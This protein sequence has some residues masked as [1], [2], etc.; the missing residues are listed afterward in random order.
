MKQKIRR[1]E[2]L[3]WGGAAAVAGVTC[4]FVRHRS[5]PALT[6]VRLRAMGAPLELTVPRGAAA[7][8][9]PRVLGPLRE[10]EQ[11]MSAFRPD[12]ELSRLNAAAASA[13]V[14]LSGPLATVLAT[15]RRF[16]RLTE[17][18]FDPTVGPLLETWG[19][20]SLAARPAGPALREAL[21]RVG[22]DRVRCDGTRVCFAAE[23]VAVDLGGIA[24]G[25]GVDQA[26]GALAAG[27]GCLVNAGGDVRAAGPRPDGAPWVVG[28][29][30]PVGG[31]GVFATIQL[32][33]NRAVTTSG[34][35]QKFVDVGR[36]RVS[37]IFDP[38]TGDSP[39]EVISA[40]VVADTAMEADALAT[41]CVV[42]G[43]REAL[44]LLERVPRVEGLLVLR[45]GG[46]HQIEGTPG[47]AARILRSV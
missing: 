26:V 39:Q 25:Y 21:G 11:R 19:F 38:R 32:E 33:A 12:S 36:R 23:G 18:A 15:C 42:L 9:V 13:E 14:E 35:Y 47:L 44:A 45:R 1:R 41:A 40:T 22:L 30:D 27:P 34:T 3:W 20:R 31:S 43:G 37:H 24:V 2:L 10:V 7:V 28:I 5:A 4:S 16:H 46:R 8:V 29:Q 17:G 6:R